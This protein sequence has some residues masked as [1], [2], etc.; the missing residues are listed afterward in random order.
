MQRLSHLTHP[1]IAEHA[2][3]NLPAGLTVGARKDVTV[4]FV[5]VRGLHALSGQPSPE[6]LSVVLNAYLTEMTRIV[7]RHGGAIDRFVGGGIKIIFSVPLPDEDHAARAVA[8][9]LEMQQRVPDLASAWYGGAHTLDLGI[10]I[11]TGPAQVRSVGC[12]Y[13][14]SYSAVGKSVRLAAHLER[15]AKAGQVL[16]TQ[17]TLEEVRHLF[18]VEPL[19][20]MQT[21]VLASPLNVYNVLGRKPSPIAVTAGGVARLNKALTAWPGVLQ[22]AALM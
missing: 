7:F 12:D 21:K 6:D 4:V 13:Y 1:L 17:R 5:N 19:G 22:P 18:A 11:N 10:G 9:A 3:C 14:M 20:A 2:P 16:I 8:M 15:R